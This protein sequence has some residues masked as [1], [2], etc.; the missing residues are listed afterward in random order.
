MI[1][2]KK[3]LIFTDTYPSMVNGVQTSLNELQKNLHTIH[4]EVI[5]ADQFYNIPFPTYREVRLSVVTPRHIMRII[6]A[7]KPD[8]IH[9]ATEWTI[10]F[11]AARACQKHN[12]PYTS[13]FHT[14]LPEYIHLRSRMI[15]EDWIHRALQY[16]HQSSKRI[17]VSSTNMRDYL[18]ENGYSRE[19]ISVLPFWVDHHTFFPWPKTLFQNIP[20]PVL[21]YV[22]RVAI[23]KN[24][25]DFL[26]IKTSGSKIVVG[27][28]PLFEKLSQAY[29]EVHFLGFKRK[30]EL[31]EIYRSADVFVFPSL[32]DTLG[33]V[34]I[35]A[36]AC[37]LPV[38]AYDVDGPNTMIKNGVNG[39]LVAY[40]KTLTSWL[41]LIGS[42]HNKD[43]VISVNHYN[44]EKYCELFLKGQVR[45]LYRQ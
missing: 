45:I 33:L 22:W 41:K 10:G 40:G 34:N 9:I 26:S 13:A 39:I 44:W 6:E 11:S 23:E 12:I 15:Q 2:R 8:Y 24:I 25:H 32:T 27:D 30:E 37:G 7:Q 29:P 21:L 17:F 3:L 36:L 20:H 14:K 31:G 5:S 4:V 18:K 43:C 42:I 19:K 28:G 1:K 38:L 16:I 35:E